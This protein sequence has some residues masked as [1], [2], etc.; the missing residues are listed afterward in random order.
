MPSS[1]RYWVSSSA[2]RLVSVVTSTRSP[3][4]TVLRISPTR[5][6]TWPRAGRTSI[7]GSSRPVGR[8]TCSATTPPARSSSKGAGVAE[9]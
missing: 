7:S 8:I 1:V 6:S 5:S 9:T 4:F 3:R 2:M